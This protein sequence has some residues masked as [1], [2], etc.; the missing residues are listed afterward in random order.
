MSNINPDVHP[1]VNLLGNKLKEKIAERNQA[2][3]NAICTFMMSNN[4]V[5]LGTDKR[6]AFF[7][8]LV[9]E[10]VKRGRNTIDIMDTTIKAFGYPTLDE[11]LEVDEDE[12]V[13][14]GTAASMTF[15]CLVPTY[16]Y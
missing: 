5:K 15:D 11:M 12:F 9:H 1:L 14:N 3:E 16:D 7:R 8:Q 4:M 6:S 2:R 10:G 13:S